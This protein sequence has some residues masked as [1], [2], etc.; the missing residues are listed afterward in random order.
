VYVLTQ[1]LN[2]SQ[3]FDRTG[4][5][6]TVFP[7]SFNASRHPRYYTSHILRT[8]A[9]S[10]IY[11]PTG[12]PWLTPA[13]R[14]LFLAPAENFALGIHHPRYLRI[15][16]NLSNF[17]PQY[18]LSIIEDP[19]LTCLQLL[20][21]NQ[22]PELNIIGCDYSS[23]AIEVVKVCAFQLSFSGYLVSRLGSRPI[24]IFTQEGNLTYFAC[25]S[26]TGSPPLYIP[27]RRFGFCMRLG[28]F[29]V[30]PSIRRRLWYG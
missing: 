11:P 22:N 8:I 10:W 19:F 2:S 3:Y 5:G 27:A 29:G 15:L 1:S 13:N 21:S 17:T 16:A 12:R 26:Y 23:K 28:P 18:M 9:F 6:N 4:A 24:L 25:F 30:K 7:V 14:L 20:E